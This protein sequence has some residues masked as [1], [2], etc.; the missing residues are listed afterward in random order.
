[1][2]KFSVIIIAY[3]E[4]HRIGALLHSIQG[5]DEVIVVDSNSTDN[6]AE[7][8]RSFGA[9]VLQQPFLGFGQQKQFGADAAQNDWVFCLDADEVPSNSCW[10]SVRA[11]CNT[12]PLIKAWYMKRHLVFMNRAFKYG[13]ESSDMQ[14]RFFDRRSAKWSIPEVHEKV[15]YEGTTG[16]LA[17]TVA[18]TSYDSI[19]DYFGKF[20]RYTSLAADDL[21][22]QGKSRSAFMKMLGVPIN[23]F[24]FYI[25]QLNI[26]N[27]YPG[28]CWSLFSSV[29][30][31]VKY[32]KAAED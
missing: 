24:K 25:L 22:K 32:S 18:H 7:V 1:M 28:F 14:L 9:K 20:N 16:T 23:F 8:S 26:L 3:N 30:T 10:S 15:E 6:T 4:G 27:G 21:K 31:L 29:Y 11:L 2:I 19:A 13:R 12:E 17:G 5:A